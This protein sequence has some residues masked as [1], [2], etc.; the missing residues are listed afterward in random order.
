VAEE[1]QAKR[2][3]RGIWGGK[4][5]VPAAYRRGEPEAEQRGP[6]SA[7]AQ[8]QDCSIKGNISK[9]GERICHVPGGTFY[10]RTKIDEGAG[11]RWFCTEQEAE[12]AGWRR[13]ER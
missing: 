10:G 5:I 4:F 8:A 11:E 6:E 12:S 7:V 9:G 2:D 3:R 1:A 13:S